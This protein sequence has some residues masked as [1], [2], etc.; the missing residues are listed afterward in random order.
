MKIPFTKF[1]LTLKKANNDMVEVNKDVFEALAG[2]DQKFKGDRPQLDPR[3]TI[4]D[5]QVL[6]PMLPLSMDIVYDVAKYSDVLRTIH[7]NLRKE[8]FR[9]GYEIKEN[10]AK[11]CND[12]DKEFQNDTD[13]CDECKSTD[14]REPKIEQKKLL[15]KFSKNVNDNNQDITNVSEELN[16]DLEIIDDAYMLGIKDYYWNDNGKLIA[17][18]PVEF[19]R[20]DPRWVRLIADKTGRPA[21]NQNNDYV[22]MCLV[23]RNE[24]HNNQTVCPTCGRET[25]PAYFRS[26]EPEGK[27]IFYTKNEICHKSKYSPSLTYGLSVIYAVWPKVITLM[28]MDLYM[29]AYYT[30]QRPPKGM[31][32]VN[33]PNM[34]S[35]E[36]AWAWAT[37]QWKKNPH[38]IPPI[39]IEQSAG[40]KGNHVTFIDLMKTLDEM[41]YTETRNEMRRQIGAAYGVM[42]IFQADL[43]TSGGLNNEGLQITVTNRAVR[44][45][46]GLYNEG[47]YP[48]YAEQLGITDYHIELN[49]NEE[50]DRMANEELEGKK[51]DNAK[52]MQDMG[53]DVTLNED[54]VFEF[55]P[56]E[57]PVEKPIP[58]MFGSEGGGNPPKEGSD[59]QSFDGEPRK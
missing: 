7:Q 40:S 42:P 22:M 11:K 9:L 41:Q 47:F 38:F 2:T 50:Q 6:I 58:Q 16:D 19:L 18:I 32:F 57:E 51:M 52:K 45:G 12:C 27:H 17:A 13:E 49:P 26:E 29:K 25:F 54:K 36:K 8:I 55:G 23:H 31:L 35:L 24:V 56:L 43:S 37:D 59:N 44:D 20:T 10:F 15:V 46:Q 48:W 21:R 39:A 30:K 28:N 14:L 1:N 3:Q 5:D 33:T 34:N 4:G 53:F